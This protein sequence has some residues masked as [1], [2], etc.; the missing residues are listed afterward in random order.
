MSLLGFWRQ[1]HSFRSVKAPADSTHRWAT[2]DPNP[3]EK[4]AED[5]RI[6]EE[7]QKAISGMLDENLVEA[8][9]TLR[10]L[11]DGD[12]ADFY[13]IEHSAPER[14]EEVDERP[15][16]KARTGDGRGLFDDEAMDNLR[17]YADMARKQAQEDNERKRK[18]PVKAVGVVSMLGGYGSGDES[19]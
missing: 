13:P 9:Q 10:A 8:A 16:K 1:L 4:V 18:M 11:E 7:G 15:V 12:E 17:F 3:T 2:E 14:E 5:K 6:E 19:D